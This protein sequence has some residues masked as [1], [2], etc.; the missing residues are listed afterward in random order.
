MH[1]DIRGKEKTEKLL[2][3]GIIR[4]SQSPFNSPLWIVP[5]KSNKLR[6]VIDYRKINEDTG[7]DAYP[8][9]V[10]DDILDQ[11]GK[12]KF[13]SAFDLSAGFHQIPMRERDKKYTAFSTSQG[14]FEYNRMPFGFRNAPATFQ[15]MKD[16]AFRG[17]IGNKCFAYIDDIVIFGDTIQ[18]HNQNMEDVLQRIKQLGLRLEPN[19]CKYLKSELEYFGHIITK[20]GVKTNP[21]KLSVI[22][23]FEELKTVKN[24]LSFPGLTGYYRKFI[25]NFLSIARP[26][27][28]LTQKDTIFDWTSL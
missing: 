27:T 4:E 24:V 26:L 14:H 20:E 1:L 22:K 17:L 7:Q 2:N 25:K 10:M 13:F 15:R 18:Q 6:M 16:N 19:K 11:L 9:P 28:K 21:E 5:K 12:A 3:K 23:N 8:L